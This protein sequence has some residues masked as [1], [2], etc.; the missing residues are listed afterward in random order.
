MAY[1]PGM[2]PVAAINPI[3]ERMYGNFPFAA[4][5]GSDNA[6]HLIMTKTVFKFELIIANAGICIR[7][8][9][10]SVQNIG[11]ALSLIEGQIV[12]FKLIRKR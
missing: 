1:G 6:D 7:G 8:P 9:N 10:N 5:K 4:I 11:T 3:A 12:L 2:M